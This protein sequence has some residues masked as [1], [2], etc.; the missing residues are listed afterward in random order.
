MKY[1]FY[2]FYTSSHTLMYA[3]TCA[4]F[5]LW[6]CNIAKTNWYKICVWHT[7]QPHLW[8]IIATLFVS[9]YNLLCQKSVCLICYFSIIK[10]I[11]SRLNNLTLHY[12]TYHL[13]FR[14]QIAFFF[15]I[16]KEM[17]PEKK[18]NFKENSAWLFALSGRKSSFSSVWIFVSLIFVLVASCTYDQTSLACHLKCEQTCFIIWFNFIWKKY[19]VHMAH[20]IL[21]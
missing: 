19:S 10:S 3:R 7:D 21:E 12:S 11:L 13:E 9:L 6:R 4:H 20:S 2:M 1:N 16:L 17:W 14:S 8:S 18:P 5:A 15:P